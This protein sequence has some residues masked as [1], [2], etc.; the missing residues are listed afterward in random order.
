MDNNPAGSLAAK[1]GRE[2][3]RSLLKTHHHA[4]DKWNKQMFWRMLSCD[5]VGYVLAWRSSIYVVTIADWVT[6]FL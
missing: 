1:K 5:L 6:A 4:M 3:L 2:T